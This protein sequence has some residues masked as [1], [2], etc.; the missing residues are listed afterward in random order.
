MNK[1]EDYCSYDLARA[2]YYKDFDWDCECA[3][4]DNARNHN[5]DL[6]PISVAYKAARDCDGTDIYPACTLSQAQKWLRE[7]K[8][9]DVS[10]IPT[11]SN[12]VE[13]IYFFGIVYHRTSGTYRDN[14]IYAT[15]EQALAAGMK[16]AIED[17]NL[18][19]KIYG[20]EN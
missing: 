10:V 7:E 1:H 14:R 18:H 17:Y 20:T 6:L 11:I 19:V 8:G 16:Y 2:M 15:Y 4:Y 13:I 3:Y 5:H 12:Y 9:Y